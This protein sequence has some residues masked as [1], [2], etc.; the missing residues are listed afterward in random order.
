LRE[1][2]SPCLRE[3]EESE[4]LEDDDEEELEDDDEEEL[5]DDDE[6]SLC[7]RGEINKG[8][9]LIASL[10]ER[11]ECEEI[12]GS[13]ESDSEEELELEELED[14][15]L[16]FEDEEDEQ[17]ISLPDGPPLQ[18]PLLRPGERDLCPLPLP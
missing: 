9:R 5:E 3:S 11:E 10:I 6:E 7:L 8:F 15:E 14:E 13:S 1:S 2:D 17:S 12:V 16:D 4:E 18:C